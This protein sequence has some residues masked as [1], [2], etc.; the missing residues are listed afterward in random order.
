[1]VEPKYL[2]SEPTAKIVDGVANVIAT[3]LK[4]VT[5]NEPEEANQVF[6]RRGDDGSTPIVITPKRSTKANGFA[7]FIGCAMAFAALFLWQIP[8]LNYVVW[9]WWGAITF[10][11]IMVLF[12]LIGLYP[13]VTLIIPSGVYALMTKHGR[14]IG[15]Y[16]A[17][18]HF[19][20]PWYK[21]AY[22]VTKQS[23]AYNAPVKNCPTADNVMIKVDL[24]LVFH[25]DDPEA[26]VYRLGAEKFGDLLA[27]SAEE[28]IRGLVRETRH[29][30]AYELRGKGAGE[31]ISGLNE[32]F[33]TFGVTFTS[34]TITNVVLPD[35]LARALENQTVYQ[36]KKREQEK[37]QE[38]E[39]KVLN[40]REALAREELNKRNERLAA[41]EIAKREREL[42]IKEAA[43]IEAQKQK[44]LAEIE[45]EEEAS[46][47]V[48]RAEGELRAAEK[49]AESLR[50]Q[51]E[52]EAF[53][54]EK[55]QTMR[56]YRLES[57]RLDILKALAA[58]NKI[59]I[60]GNNGDNI[61][62]QL[63]AATRSYDVMSLA[64]A[65]ESMGNESTDGSK[66]IT[67]E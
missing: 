30:S 53:A 47:L 22:M 36:S 2:Q 5:I 49:R 31:M 57:K 8:V 58:N 6:G 52:A 12:L 11:P 43:E 3:R 32:Q 42:I 7:L 24:L 27:S 38:Y 28:A 64:S 19:L 61:I 45:A 26:F 37:H 23:T 40:D 9:S 14:Y 44:L 10:W 29:D 15:I 20:P 39:M 55:L 60:S 13:L 59:I 65:A 51:S 35:E 18:R 66:A 17:G 21:V 62:A 25:V 34:A 33:K 16:D 1:M 56:A 63:T 54:A 4:Q 48:T 50:I 41:D 46:V 67:R